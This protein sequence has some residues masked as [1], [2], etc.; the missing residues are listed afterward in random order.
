MKRDIYY[1]EQDSNDKKQVNIQRYY[2]QGDRGIICVEYTGIRL[3]PNEITIGRIME[4][5]DCCKQYASYSN[6]E[7]VLTDLQDATTLPI[8]EFTEETPCGKYIDL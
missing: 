7:Y 6:E 8:C 5:I 2:Y 4:E 1:V 3:K